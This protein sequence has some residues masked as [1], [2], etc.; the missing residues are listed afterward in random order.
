[1]ER[2][3]LFSASSES[4]LLKN[5]WTTA[6]TKASAGKI[7]GKRKPISL[8]KATLGTAAVGTTVYVLKKKLSNKQKSYSTIPAVVDTT[9][10]VVS[11]SP[12]KK[13]NLFGKAVNSWRGMGTL[14]KGAL[15][16][17]A[18]AGTALAI[19]AFKPKK[20][21]K[22]YSNSL[23][24]ESKN[25]SFELKSETG[26]PTVTKESFNW[27]KDTDKLN[28]S[29]KAYE[30]ALKRGDRPTIQSSARAYLNQWTEDIYIPARKKGIFVDISR[31]IVDD[32]NGKF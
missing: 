17:G 3:K 31:K 7:I 27:Q 11:S 14:G 30:E 8:G 15:L 6:K 10:Q 1:M 26:K 20:K 32:A 18:A 13:P 25:H 4:R 12:L 29:R 23:I 21:E 24:V 2:R 5:R 28:E 22:E 19:N 16:A 9:A